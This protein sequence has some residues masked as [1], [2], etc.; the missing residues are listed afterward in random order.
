LLHWRGKKDLATHGTLSR[1]GGR[2]DESPGT[3]VARS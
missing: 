3:A 1:G 2:G